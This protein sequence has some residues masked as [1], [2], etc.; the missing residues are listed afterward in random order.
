MPTPPPS[1][2]VRYYARDS[3]PLRPDVPGARYRAVALQRTMLT[4]F[5]VQ[6]GVRFETHRHESEQITWVL[7]GE[8]C[9]E[10]EGRLI[11]LQAGEV[12]AIPALEP[13]A[14]FTRGGAARALDAWSPVPEKYR[15]NAAP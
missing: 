10:V 14:V 9:F 12:I 13:H 8:L 4:Y 7:E 2:A 6:P 11:P 5:E 3:L 15:G 1:D